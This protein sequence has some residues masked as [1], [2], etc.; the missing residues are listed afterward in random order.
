[1]FKFKPGDFVF[2]DD[3]FTSASA[4]VL[5][6]FYA[7]A[8]VHRTD[9]MHTFKFMCGIIV[10]IV[11]EQDI[12]TS[13]NDPTIFVIDSLTSRMGW[14]YSNHIHTLDDDDDAEAR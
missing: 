12:A 6:L 8:Y 14:V 3:D 4:C 1:M 7:P 11:E 13:G 10:A 5:G 2:A 9:N